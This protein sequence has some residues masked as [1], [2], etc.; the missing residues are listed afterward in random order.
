MSLAKRPLSPHLQIYKPQITSS[1]SILHRIA[2][3]GLAFGLV[4]LVS[5]L[6][7]IAGGSE[8]YASFAALAQTTIG[9]IILFALTLGFFAHLCFGIRHLFW[10]IGKYLEIKDVY[11]TGRIAILSALLLTAIVW[12]KVY[13]V[14]L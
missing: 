11:K 7:A 10:D 1:L 8:T 6:A 2:G 14:T 12:L 13:G 4:I 9:Q 3:I 5:W